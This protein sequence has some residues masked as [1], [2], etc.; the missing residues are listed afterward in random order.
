MADDHIDV[1]GPTRVRAT[2]PDP[3]NPPVDG[4]DAIPA[5]VI[6]GQ[7]ELLPGGVECEEAD[8]VFWKVWVPLL[9][10]KGLT[11]IVAHDGAEVV[12][13][14]N[15]SRWVADCPCGGAMHCWDRNPYGCCLDCGVLHKVR[16]QPPAKRAEVT[17]LLAGRPV[18]HRNWD[19]H[20]GE[21]VE[22]LKIQNVLMHGAPAVERDGLLVAAN[23]KMP[24]RFTHPQEYLE[25][26]QTA[27]RKAEAA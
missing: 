20:K 5:G 22:E 23:V 18:Q 15:H 2:P 4:G 27:R 10:R 11:P 6:L 1:G 12:P 7:R 24:K 16:W 13:Y 19:A 8:D 25:H 17:R 14:I 3:K 26:L 21:T 9:E